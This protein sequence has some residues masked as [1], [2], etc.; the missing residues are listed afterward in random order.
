MIFR[1]IMV[2]YGKIGRDL[3][4]ILSNRRI[5]LKRKYDIETTLVAVLDSTGGAVSAE[6]LNPALLE[7]AKRETGR[8][9]Q[10]PKYGLEGISVEEAIDEANADLM[11]DISS[12][13][14]RTG[15]PAI[16]NTLMGIEKGLNIVTT[17][18]G[19]LAIGYPEMRKAARR[20]GVSI[21]FRGSA[22]T[23]L[24]FPDIGVYVALGLLRV[25][26]IEC[27]VNACTNYILGRMHEGADKKRAIE[28]A[29]H[30][31]EPDPELDLHGWDTACKIA[32]LANTILGRDVV[33]KDVEH[34]EG[35]QN[36]ELKDVQKAVRNGKRMRH[37]G[38]LETSD[39]RFSMRSETKCYP[40]DHPFSALKKSEKVMIVETLNA[41]RIV[42]RSE[43]TGS[44]PSAE[45]VVH[46]IIDMS[47]CHGGRWPS[48]EALK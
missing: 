20:R 32:I 34:V 25:T 3:T 39:G 15:E 30:L 11:I 16:S 38:R 43:H 23:P 45:A 44:L 41:G 36:I 46:D 4:E 21:G 40:I 14:F 17:N 7:E 9:C 27:V 6:G 31:L 42:V 12:T 13:N 19:A 35:I 10:Y 8:V 22:A 18:K 1:I 26:G 48:T 33:L 5:E 29:R 24:P 28:D 2:G 37:V 47:R